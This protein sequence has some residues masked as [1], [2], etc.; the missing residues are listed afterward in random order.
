VGIAQA[1]F[2]EIISIVMFLLLGAGVMK[3]FQMAS[4]I[5]D[6]KDAVMD[7]KR[8]A[9]DAPTIA[10]REV[11]RTASPAVGTDRPL[12]SPEELVRAVHSGS[13]KDTEFSTLN[14]TT[15]PQS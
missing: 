1:F 13:Y 9:V 5:R 10:A 12:M 4:D 11:T 2:G 14:P 6:M 3:V 8:Y 15:P 7:I